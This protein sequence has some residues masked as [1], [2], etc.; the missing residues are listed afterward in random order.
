[1]ATVHI[2]E[3]YGDQLFSSSDR[4]PSFTLHFCDACGKEHER[5]RFARAFPATGESPITEQLRVIEISPE[6]TIV[7]LVRTESQPIPE[8][9]ILV[10]ERL[11]ER[12]CEVG[13]E[14]SITITPSELE[15]LKGNR[16][17]M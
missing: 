15:Y 11:P 8:N 10:T 14:F 16:D 7:R 2:A 1:M 12:F 17:S 9:W 6:H 5:E 13:M 4:V 3:K